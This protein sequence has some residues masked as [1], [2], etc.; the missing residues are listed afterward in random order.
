MKIDSYTEVW[1]EIQ[2]SKQGADDW[3]S[4]SGTSADSIDSARERLAHCIKHNAEFD[5]RI[6]KKTLAEEV[7]A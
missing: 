7:V 5:F 3:F 6:I 4:A 2:W 1:F